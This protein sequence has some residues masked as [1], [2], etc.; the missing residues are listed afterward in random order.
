MFKSPDHIYWLFSSAAQAIAAFIG[1]LSAGFFFVYDHMQRQV[2]KDETLVEIYDELKKQ[3]YRRLE[4]LL[5]FT[6]LTIV[7]SLLGLDCC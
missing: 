2:D 3:Y 6:G 4:W 1:F 7:S 5:V